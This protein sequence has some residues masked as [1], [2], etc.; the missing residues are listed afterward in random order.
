MDMTVAGLVAPC[1]DLGGHP[2]FTP[3]EFLQAITAGRLVTR[4]QLDGRDP[5]VWAPLPRS[6]VTRLLPFP[7]WAPPTRGAPSGGGGTGAEPSPP[8]DPSGME[9]SGGDASRAGVGV[10]PSPS[11]PAMGTSPERTGEE[12]RGLAGG[13]D[14]SPVPS[15]RSGSSAPAAVPVGRGESPGRA[16]SSGSSLARATP[17]SLVSPPVA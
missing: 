9:A 10:A 3:L 11:Q 4:G 2:D 16:A 6:I 17:S 1:V 15:R 7:P 13:M 5:T 12:T 8:P 14:S